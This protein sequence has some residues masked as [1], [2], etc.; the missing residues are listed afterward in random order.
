MA[1]IKKWCKNQ[2]VEAKAKLESGLRQSDDEGERSELRH[3]QAVYENL[4]RELEQ[5]EIGEIDMEQGD[6]HVS[7]RLVCDDCAVRARNYA[8]LLTRLP[9]DQPELIALLQKL[10]AA[11]DQTIVR[12]RPYL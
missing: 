11:E 1:D 9:E 6:I 4:E 5:M 12:L 7:A 8:A 3:A 10:V 2:M